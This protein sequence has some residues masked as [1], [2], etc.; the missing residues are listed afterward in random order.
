MAAG[1]G[2][3]WKE[4][5]QSVFATVVVLVLLWFCR[6]SLFKQDTRAGGGKGLS[7]VA[8]AS[9]DATFQDYSES[10][11]ESEE[12]EETEYPTIMS[13]PICSDLSQSIR[14]LQDARGNLLKVA[15]DGQ[16]EA[17]LVAATRYREVLQEVQSCYG[18]LKMRV[19]PD[20]L[21]SVVEELIGFCN[22]D[23][24]QIMV[25]VE[26]GRLEQDSWR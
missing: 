20:D 23:E 3:R 19:V 14:A 10:Y 4:T 5:V 1:T 21:S 9:D 18:K 12:E 15:A 26:L 2:N 6:P 22:T 13:M 24:Q 25:P 16:P 8:L 11:D 17:V 7:A